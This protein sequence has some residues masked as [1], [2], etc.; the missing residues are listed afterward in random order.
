MGLTPWLVLAKLQLGLVLTFGLER[1][2][3]G[4][5]ASSTGCRIRRGRRLHEDSRA[6]AGGRRRKQEITEGGKISFAFL[7]AL[8]GSA[9]GILLP[10]TPTEVHFGALG[11]PGVCSLTASSVA[12]AANSSAAS[13]LS[14]AFS[15]K[16]R[17]PARVS[18]R[19]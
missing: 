13:T 9:R 15:K 7:R 5:T 2:K 3:D 12:R 10:G 19:M 4:I 14:A 17:P 8:G 6:E 11:A 1:M 16:R 18:M